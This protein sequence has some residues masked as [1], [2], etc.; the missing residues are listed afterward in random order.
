MSADLPLPFEKGSHVLFTG[1]SIT[2]AGRTADR[3]PYGG[4]YVG[5]IQ[6][7]VTAQAPELALRWT[8]RGIS[9]NTVR[10]LASRWQADV[11]DERPD[12][13]CVKIGIND[14]WRGM[15][16]NADEAVPVAE[17][18]ETLAALLDRATSATGCRLVVAT[19]YLIEGDRSDPWRIE[20][21][22]YVAAAREVARAKG[23]PLVDVQAAFDRVLAHTAPADWA[24]DRVHPVLA[25]HAVIA[26]AFLAVFAGLAAADAHA[27]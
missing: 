13:L 18:Q 11:L 16:G 2:D 17:Y 20:S 25:G 19:P 4:G 5:L 15:E 8:N 24:G 26:R 3:A 14:C 9:G 21:D 6:A 12:W 23:L 27:G 1:D 22:R 7:L 10:D